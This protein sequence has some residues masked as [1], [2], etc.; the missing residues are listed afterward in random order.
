MIGTLR[1]PRRWSLLALTLVGLTVAVSPAA[2][3]PDLPGVLVGRWEG[4]ISGRSAGGE[5]GPHRTL[6]IDGVEQKDGKWVAQGNYGVTGRSLRSTE[7][8]VQVIDGTPILDFVSPGVRGNSKI[9]LRLTGKVLR[10]TLRPVG[11]QSDS[12]LRLERV[13]ATP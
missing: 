2:A 10:G 1:M 8:A 7:I 5:F 3:Q 12:E 11:T 13:S 9:S 4:Q 6:V